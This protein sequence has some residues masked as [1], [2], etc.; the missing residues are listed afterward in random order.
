MLPKSVRIQTCKWTPPANSIPA[1][2]VLL[3]GRMAIRPVNKTRSTGIEFAGVNKTRSARIEFAP[4]DFLPIGTLYL[5]IH[6][7]TCRI[8]GNVTCLTSY[9][10]HPLKVKIFTFLL[11]FFFSIAYLETSSLGNT[12]IDPIIYFESYL[13]TLLL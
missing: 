9:F 8:P 10:P 1:L 5:H 12:L 4:T 2:L 6:L 7:E 13:E 3:T 11:C